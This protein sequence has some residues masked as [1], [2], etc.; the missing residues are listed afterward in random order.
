MTP[1]TA[2]R[3]LDLTV[4]YVQSAADRHPCWEGYGGEPAGR[5]PEQIAAEYA[6]VFNDAATPPTG[7]PPLSAVS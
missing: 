5:D 2:R 4:E 1:D 3:L 7:P 6:Q